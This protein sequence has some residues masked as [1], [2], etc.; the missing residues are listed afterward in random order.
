MLR[1]ARH[2][3]HRRLAVGMLTL[4]ATWRRVRRATRL[5]HRSTSHWR[6]SSLGR[7][8]RTWLRV[9]AERIC[10]VGQLRE[11][12]RSLLHRKLAAS[13][14][15]WSRHSTHALQRLAALEAHAIQ[16]E[17]LAA[18]HAMC[19]WARMAS[20]RRALQAYAL[21]YRSSMRMR[22]AWMS[23]LSLWVAV[24]GSRLTRGCHVRRSAIMRQ[25]FHA[26]RDVDKDSSEP[27]RYP[28][29]AD[30]AQQAQRDVHEHPLAPSP[31]RLAVSTKMREMLDI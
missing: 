27:M 31:Y 21:A 11:V 4:S 25:Q 5:V 10:A 22:R 7:G 8:W 3:V 28:I 20:R 24:L 18:R 26:S 9:V 6:D 13:V 1:S 12:A 29:G 14:A 16:L 19:A 30:R 2:L 23:W 17:Q 15:S